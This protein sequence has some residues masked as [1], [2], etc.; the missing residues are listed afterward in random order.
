MRK[1][2]RYGLTAAVLSFALGVAAEPQYLTL[3][4]YGLAVAGVGSAGLLATDV[5]GDGVADL[6]S[7]SVG[8]PVV[9][10]KRG[11]EYVPVWYGPS[12]GCT[13]IT[14]GDRNADGKPEL[15][16]GTSN[17]EIHV[18]DPTGSIQAV[19][20]A[21]LPGTAAI[22]DIEIGDVDSDGHAEI[23]AVTSDHAY[24][25]GGSTLLLEWLATSQ[26][27]REVRIGN[28]DDDG[29]TEIVINGPTG[30]VL[31][32][33]AQ[34]LKWGY[35]G[36][37]GERMTIGNVD[38]D[39]EQEIVFGNA[40]TVRI[41]NG[42]DF[43][44]SSFTVDAYNTHAIAVGDANN[45]G[46]PEIIHGRDQWGSIRGFNTTGTQ[47]WA[48]NNPDH[49]VSAIVVGDV[50]GDGAKEVCWGAGLTSSGN[51]VLVIANTSAVE[52]SLTE[53]DGGY[54]TAVAD[55][56]GDGTRELIVGSY[57]GV[58]ILDYATKTLEGTLKF[59]DGTYGGAEVSQ[60]AVGQLD[61]D[62]ALEVLA[63]SG[64]DLF[65]FDGATRAR[66]WNTQNNGYGLT[67]VSR[68]L[69]VANIDNDP[70]DEIIIGLSDRSV[71]ALNGA[72]PIIQW[73]S[74]DLGGYIGD[75]DIADVNNDGAKDIVVGSSYGVHILTPSNNSAP[76]IAV[77]GGVSEV[78][79]TAG[80]FAVMS[81][82]YYN[83]TLR[84][85]GPSLTQEWSCTLTTGYDYAYA[86]LLTF[87]NIVGE[88]LL[89][90]GW[91][92]KIV[93]MPIGGTQC[94]A[95]TTFYNATE[96]VLDIGFAEVTGDQY[97]EL[98]IST[99]RAYEILAIG[100]TTEPRGDVDRDG[101]VTDVDI[102]TLTRYLLADGAGIAPSADVDGNG[103]VDLADLFYLIHY[104]RGTGPA[105]VP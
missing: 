10:S 66:Q 50:D 98:L 73:T 84:S 80:R 96:P 94:P 2:V 11:S 74:N 91:N 72:T 104:R 56:D 97:P 51:D 82:D 6:V 55:L 42:D 9:F 99:S 32:A 63:M 13:A 76:K 58:R 77:S 20:K 60:L 78:A 100:S 95:M 43:S 29:R 65:A 52:A 85:Y 5:T 40:A 30:R 18:F 46:T 69:A 39:P 12:V 37:F 75:I 103:R 86:R 59:Y 44:T 67:Y 16:V 22:N 102:E 14:V 62:P 7:C 36:G 88:Q 33:W 68:S 105:P 64:Y 101:T 17:R 38:G 19:A 31:D 53:F 47:L 70:I 34:A 27:G 92:G 79:A 93:S 81:G 35:A 48:V 83:P 3:Y 87:A 28:I 4:R 8:T 26:G 23:V 54:A 45:D 89:L 49:G 41:L 25:Y 24:I 57:G 90:A 61:N 1:M 15:I 71:I 21:T